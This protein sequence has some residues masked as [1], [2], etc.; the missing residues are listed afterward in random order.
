MMYSLFHYIIA[1]F[2]LYFQV[3]PRTN[4]EANAVFCYF[5]I[6]LIIKLSINDIINFIYHIIL[7]ICGID[8]LF[9]L[10][11]HLFTAGKQNPN[12]ILNL[13]KYMSSTLKIETAEG[14]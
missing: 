14:Y 7:S 13:Q 2:F 12:A 6:V 5:I 4:L 8:Y 9:I 11:A 10:F 3:P 1:G